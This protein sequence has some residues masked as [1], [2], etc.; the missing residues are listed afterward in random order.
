[1][2]LHNGVMSMHQKY[3]ID[4]QLQRKKKI[5]FFNY[6]YWKDYLQKKDKVTR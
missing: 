4:S 3:H 1:M 5:I 2:Y 6:K